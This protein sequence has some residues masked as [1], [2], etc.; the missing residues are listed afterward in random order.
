V[1]GLTFHQARVGTSSFHLIR[2]GCVSTCI[3]RLVIS[4]ISLSSPICGQPD[5]EYVNVNSLRSPLGCNI[6]IWTS[7]GQEL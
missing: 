5:T 6:E 2:G 7:V 4:I 1:P 3:D